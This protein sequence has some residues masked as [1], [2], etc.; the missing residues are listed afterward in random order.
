MLLKNQTKDI[1]T[2]PGI[3][4]FKNKKEEILYIGKAKN[5]RNRVRSY[6]SKGNKNIKSQ[7]IASK[8]TAIDFLVVSNEVEAI[9]TEA[10]MI[11]EYRPKYNICLKD[12]KTFPYIVITSEIFPKVEIIRKKTLNKDDNVYFGPYSDV[13]YLRGVVKALYRIF[14]IKTCSYGKNKKETCFCGFCTY[15]NPITKEDYAKVIELVV[16]FLKGKAGTVKDEIKKLMHKA[17]KSFDFE[18]AATYRDQLAAIDSFTKKQKKIAHDFNNY[19]IVHALSDNKYG[20]GMVMRVR[21]GLLVGKESFEF[22][23][24]GEQ[25]SLEEM[26]R[27]FLIQYYDKTLDIPEELII[28]AALKDKKSIGDWLSSKKGR[29]VL[30]ISPKIGNKKKMLDLCIRNT[31]ISLKDILIKKI[32]RKKYIPKTLEELKKALLM[33]KNPT[34]IEAFDNSNLQGTNPV[35]ALVCFVN[36]KPLKKEYRKFNIKTVVGIDDFKSMGEVIFRCYS[37][38]IKEGKK[39]PD[40]I[41]IDGGKGQLSYAKKTLNKLGLKD[42]AVIGLAKRMEEVFLPGSNYPQNIKKNSPA[43]FL[44][45]EIRDEVHRYAI[46]FHREKRSNA[47]FDSILKK[48]PGLGNTR[49]QALFNK[50]G[51][52]NKMILDNPRQISKKT[53]IPISICEQIIKVLKRTERELK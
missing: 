26:L 51:N 43:L 16:D 9:I 22:K 38:R 12:D 53:K 37:R 25:D 10:N 48:I 13:S 4:F 34:R 30:I 1:P 7:V 19:D 3:Y 8:A 6:F 31:N 11:K 49:Y 14:P 23:L 44:L 28:D 47:S 20:L 24:P 15:G 39:L 45:R 35:S 2:N 42:I 21:N 52:T 46:S 41:L 17:S 18:Q 36:G 32:K 27:G 5:L 50:Y 33:K 29:K 40:L